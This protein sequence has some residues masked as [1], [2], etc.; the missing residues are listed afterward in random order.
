M[1]RCR[2]GFLIAERKESDR[3]RTEGR[4]CYEIADVGDAFC[5]AMTILESRKYL[6]SAR[7][8]ADLMDRIATSPT[9]S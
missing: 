7:R 6:A 1:Q 5:F 3:T 8:D 2:D 4:V 9:K